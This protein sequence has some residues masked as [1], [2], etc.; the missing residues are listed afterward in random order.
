MESFAEPPM[1]RNAL[2]MAD[3]DASGRALA[4]SVLSSG[5]GTR[6][7]DT[8][9]M[10]PRAE[11]SK[12]DEDQDLRFDHDGVAAPLPH[13]DD[14]MPADLSMVVERGSN[15]SEPVR[16]DILALVRTAITSG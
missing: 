9:I 6:T 3:L 5:G 15:L 7:P 10:I 4:G 11:Q 8:R 2:R 14:P 16:A 1:D 13:N 12:S